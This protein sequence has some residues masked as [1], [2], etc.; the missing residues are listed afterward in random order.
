M[1]DGIH[2][3]PQPDQ[4]RLGLPIGLIQEAIAL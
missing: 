4:P 3:V 2:E 1:Q